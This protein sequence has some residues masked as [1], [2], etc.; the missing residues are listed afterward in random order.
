MA[1]DGQELVAHADDALLHAQLVRVTAAEHGPAVLE[2]Q[3]VHRP[4][5]DVRQHV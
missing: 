5:A 4:V 2:H 3:G 1:A